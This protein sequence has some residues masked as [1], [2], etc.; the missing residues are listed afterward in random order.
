MRLRIG[1]LNQHFMISEVIGVESKPP[2]FWFLG[3]Y[4]Q[5]GWFTLEW[6]IITIFSCKVLVS[7]LLER[8]NSTDK[9]WHHFSFRFIEKLQQDIPGKRV[10]QQL[11]VLCG[12][13]SLALLH[14]HQGDFLATSCITSKQASL[15]ND[16]LRELYTQVCSQKYL[17]FTLFTE[18]SSTDWYV[19]SWLFVRFGLMLLH[20]SMHLTTRITSLVQFLAA[21]MVMCIQN[22]TRLHG[23]IL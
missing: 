5:A 3:S 22:F 7:C 9:I 1:I 4:P 18:G 11:E 13:Y 10:K 16:Q 14:K 23:R 15:A 12:I 20:S 2:N 8:W 17:I 21:M 6:F 19:T